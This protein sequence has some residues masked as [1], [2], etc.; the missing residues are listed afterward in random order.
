MP[1][2]YHTRFIK[3]YN[4]IPNDTSSEFGKL[5]AFDK[6]NV[7]FWVKGY[8]QTIILKNHRILSYLMKKII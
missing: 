8:K 5:L 1:N 2:P 6:S 7:G 4:K 3:H